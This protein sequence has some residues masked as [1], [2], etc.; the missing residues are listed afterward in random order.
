MATVLP[1]PSKKQRTAAADRAREQQEIK[2]D[3]P[4][5]LGNIRLRFYDE[6]TGKSIGDT[7]SVPVADAT[8]KNLEL[9]VNSLL[10]TQVGRSFSS[11]VHRLMVGR[12]LLNAYPT[13]LASSTMCPP[14]EQYPAAW[15]LGATSITRYSNQRSRAQKRE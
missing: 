5:D 11:E 1:P 4:A 6:T 15:I 2:D 10:G 13:G 7:I 3:I 12:M 14:K 9:L 8:V